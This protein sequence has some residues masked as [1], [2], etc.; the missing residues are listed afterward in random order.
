MPQRSKRSVI[1]RA[2]VTAAAVTVGVLASQGV[3]AADFSAVVMNCSGVSPNVV[4]VPY[5]AQV[6]VGQYGGDPGWTGITVH[7][8]ASIWGGYTSRPTLTW[9]NLATGVTGTATGQYPVSSFFGTGGQ[10][11][12]NA[13]DIGGGPVRFDL[14]AVNTGLFPVPPVTCSAVIDI[15]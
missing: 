5:S 14:T 4:D 7:T 3:A 11:N 1:G 15:P 8:G 13:R 2:A 6:Y 10:A 9:T 12:F